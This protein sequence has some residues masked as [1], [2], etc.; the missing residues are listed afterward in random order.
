MMRF[1]FAG[2]RALAVAIVL[3]SSVCC[4]QS[5][6]NHA[7]ASADAGLDRGIALAEDGN[8]DQALPI[9]KRAI[10]QSPNRDLLKRS[11]LDGLRCAMTHNSYLDSL[12]FLEVLQREFPRDPEVLYAATHAYS[13]LSQHASQDLVREAPFSYQVHQL[14]AESLEVQ[15]RYDEAA[16]EYRK[17]LEISPLL[18]GI[19]YRLGRDLM[20]KQ[21]PSA[22]DVAE[23]KRQFEQ[24]LEID[25]KNAGAE[26][27][28]G[29]L[30]RQDN[31]LPLAI[32]HFSRATKLDAAF[33]E[34]YLGL[35]TALVSSK[36]FTDAISPLETY[37][38]LEPDSPTGHYQ[39]A[40]AYSGAGRKEDANR[41]ASLQRESAANLEQVKRKI[42]E[43]VIGSQPQTAAPVS[44]K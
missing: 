13:D 33:S 22:A 21:N 23:A 36:R 25:P 34:A 4:A 42:A 14:S 17:I 6:A 9:L 38:K 26:Y 11:G 28:L 35:G 18:P 16:G 19:H 29:E 32:R 43:G 12:P 2:S 5:S 10:R 15:G 27:V 7:R 8:C 41:E 40:L 37:E 24:E 1:M 39:L 20:S 3:L 30:A 31:D 44:P